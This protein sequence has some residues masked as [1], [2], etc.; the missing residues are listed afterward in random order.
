MDSLIY[1]INIHDV[2]RDRADYWRLSSLLHTEMSD[3]AKFGIVIGNFD[4]PFVPCT[5]VIHE[6][7]PFNFNVQQ[8]GHNVE[9]FVSRL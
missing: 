1:T 5:N 4:A 2:T 9:T 7:S 3:D 8:S 6:R